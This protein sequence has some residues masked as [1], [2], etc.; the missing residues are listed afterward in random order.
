V[1][2][3]SI[4]DVD[5]DIF[6]PAALG[7]SINDD[8]ID[9]LK[10]KVIAGAANN[11]LADPARHAEMLHE[12]GIV[13]VP[14]Y[15]INAG[16]LISIAISLDGHYSE[17]QARKQTGEIY[18]TVES[19]LQLSAEHGVLTVAAADRLAEERIKILGKIGQRFIA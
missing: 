6:S 9:R 12:R 3:D 17:E 5:C 18:N 14:D 1:T 16:G 2:P 10:A 11:Q 8:T 13:Y 4:Y 7:A 19:I 15:V